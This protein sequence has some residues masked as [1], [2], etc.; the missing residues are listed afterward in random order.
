[1]SLLIAK[2]NEDRSIRLLSDGLAC[3][4]GGLVAETDFDKWI[5][6]PCV[7]WGIGVAGSAAITGILR[8]YL[9]DERKA[10]GIPGMAPQL[11]ALQLL[12]DCR[13]RLVAAG[14]NFKHED[15]A[16]GG[17]GSDFLIVTSCDGGHIWHSPGDMQSLYP[18]GDF[19]AI[20]VVF[21]IAAALHE[22][23]VPV[24]EVFGLAAHRHT[25]VGNIHQDLVLRN[26]DAGS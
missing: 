25:K 13:E 11:Q 5:V 26:P 16:A 1:M 15:H 2:R 23:R 4:E 7:T 19:A 3:Y 12:D 21:D 10:W 6:S 14:V 17:C 8:R 9:V 20:G 22:A 24:E 18:K